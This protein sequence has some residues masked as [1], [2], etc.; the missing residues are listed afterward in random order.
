M[1]LQRFLLIALVT[2][3]IQILFTARPSF[4]HHNEDH[5]VTLHTNDEWEECAIVLDPSLTQGDFHDFIG[6]ISEYMY[7]RPLAG[8]KPLGKFNFDLTLEMRS[9][10]IEDWEPKWNNTFSHPDHDHTLAGDDHRL[11]IPGL[12]GRMGI[13]DKMDAELFLSVNTDSNYGFTGLAIKYA[14][15]DDPDLKWA[16]SVRGSYTTL[17]GV[18][19]MDMNQIAADFVV[20]RD[21]WYFRPYVGGAL[22]LS[23][24]VETTDKVDLSDETPLS[25]MAL[26]GTQFVWKYLSA[27]IE[28]SFGRLSI[29]S[30]KIGATF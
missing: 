1:R 26:I 27:G 23:Y 18:D 30:V 17:L 8:A 7:L 20:S 2:A 3:L 21:I 14:F 6:E 4:A 9:A 16:A 25:P 15:I 22:A 28:Q 13:T 10:E 24:G 11:S 5:T 12:R 19:D 29:T